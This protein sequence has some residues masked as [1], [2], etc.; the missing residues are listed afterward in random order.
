[1][2]KI[3]AACM[4]LSMFPERGIVRDA[5]GSGVRV[6]GFERRASILFRVDGEQV[7]ILRILYGGQDYPTDHVD[8]TDS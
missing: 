1:V 6:V 4:A 8:E 5:I 3:E 7:L 2:R